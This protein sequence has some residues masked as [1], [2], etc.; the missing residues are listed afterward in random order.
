[1]KSVLRREALLRRSVYGA[2][3]SPEEKEAQGRR[4]VDQISPLI[5]PFS[6]ISL[7]WSM[8]EEISTRP[9]LEALLQQR[10]T[11]LLPLLN[12]ASQA[13]SFHPYHKGDPLA[14]H[15]LGFYEPIPKTPPL[16]PDIL[17]VPLV[18]FDE[19]GHRLGYGKGHYD[20]TISS[21][22]K[23]NPSLITAGLA[24]DMQKLASIPNDSF[25]EPLDYVLTPNKIYS[26]KGLS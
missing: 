3:L 20:R 11:V 10:K 14:H 12:E 4:L 18:A 15:P 24:Y 16:I 25:D 26:Y 13:L 7:Y 5:K 22:K 23:E 9:L 6:L 1:M 8:G 21:L 19:N 2:S 17:F